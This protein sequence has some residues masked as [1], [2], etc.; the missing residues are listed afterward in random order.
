MVKLSEG[1]ETMRNDS[2]LD[3]CFS[4][5]KYD[6]FSP[7]RAKKIENNIL[8]PFTNLDSFNEVSS[9]RDSQGS[10][11]FADL[12]IQILRPTCFT[13]MSEG[14]KPLQWMGK[15]TYALEVDFGFD[16]DEEWQIPVIK[17]WLSKHGFTE[18]K[19]PW[20]SP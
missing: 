16:L 14:I 3:S 17:Y 6:M 12:S 10:V 9:I 7:T 15:K 5:V 1:I 20:S 8:L 18:S 4:V 2:T 19:I 13:N 11:Y